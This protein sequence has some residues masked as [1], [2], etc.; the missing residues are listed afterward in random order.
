MLLKLSVEEILDFI[1]KK[2]AA[3]IRNNPLGI[4]LLL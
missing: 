1:T 3:S 4:F 2:R